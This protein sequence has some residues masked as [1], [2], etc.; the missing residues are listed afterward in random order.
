[1]NHEMFG[2]GVPVT[3]QSIRTLSS[4]ATVRSLRGLS[5]QDGDAGNI[6]NQTFL[7][8]FLFSVNSRLCVL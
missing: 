6:K 8:H 3:L 2:D 5:V 4:S 7:T 1:M